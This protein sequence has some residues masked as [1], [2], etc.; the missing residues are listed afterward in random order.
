M[1]QETYHTSKRKPSGL[2]HT[3]ENQVK[4]HREGGYDSR[5]KRRRKPPKGKKRQKVKYLFL[6]ILTITAALFTGSFLWAYASLKKG[7]Q[8]FPFPIKEL[9]NPHITNETRE[10]MR[11][12]WTIAVFGVDSAD[13]SLGKGA[14]A[15]VIMLCNLNQ[16]TGAVRAVSIYRD[17]CMKVG[18]QNPYKKINEA[19]ARGGTYQAVK[20]LNENLDLEIDD[21]V[22]INW[23]A[24]ADAINLLGGI[25]VD[26][27]Q[28][29]FAYIN[30]YITSTV[31][32]SGV[33]SHQLKAPGP[34]HLDGVQ[35]VAYARLRKMDTDFQ[36]TERQ[37]E[38]VEK[39]LEKGKQA[40][41]AT[42]TNLVGGVLPQVSTSLEI[43]DLLPMAA[44]LKKYYL[45]AAAGFPFELETRRIRENNHS[46]DYVFPL[47]L[48]DN[49]RKLHDF[50][51][52]NVEY[53]V[54]EQ[55]KEISRAVEKK[56]QQSKEKETHATETHVTETDAAETYA[57]E[58]FDPTA[59][60]LFETPSGRIKKPKRR[61]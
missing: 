34:N 37:R 53:H 22:A 20:A 7:Q 8:D 14:N 43:S 56:R 10:I 59:A 4:I 46:I 45:E 40:D 55:V 47:D 18:E 23:K 58:S 48:E 28:A 15:D 51:Y 16:R 12:N 36:R 9:E 27:S 17:T 1:R 25:E 26:L 30:S 31:E 42:L 54:S 3:R 13:G 49:V 52:E 11:E 24:A 29:E 41:L 32:G 33:G 5:Y 61:N 21:Y 35:A 38:V 19:Y 2:E 60:E 57:T 44:D 6:A 50:L 39:V